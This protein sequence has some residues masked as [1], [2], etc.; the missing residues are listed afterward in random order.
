MA[1]PGQPRPAYALGCWLCLRLVGVCYLA[2]FWSF[3]VQVRGL[4]GEDGILP[5]RDV[6]GAARQ[7]ADAADL[8][9]SRLFEVPTLLWLG[10]SDAWLVGLCVAG[11]ALSVPV[12]LGVAAHLALPLLWLLYLSLSTVTREFLSFQWD[13]LLLETG[14]LS[15]ALAPWVLVHRPGVGEPP[16][17]ARWLVWWLIF[18]LMLTSGLVKLT[19]DDP[20]WRDLSALAYHYETQPLPS[21]IGW[22]AHHLPLFAHRACAAAMFA[23]ELAVPWLIF[24]GTTGRRAAAAAFIGLMLLVA[25][26]GN[27]AF[28]NLLTIA[29][30]CSLI[31]TRGPRVIA[32]RRL[33]WVPAAAIAC[34]TLPATVDVLA[35]QTGIAVPE[36]A[37]LQAWRRAI[38]P[39]RSVNAYGLFAVMSS[40]RP[41][42]AVEGSR[43][44]VTWVPYTFKYKPGDVRQRPRWVA[45]HQPRLD[46]HMWFAALDEYERSDWLDRFC[47][48]LLDGA[49][50]VTGLLA[51]NP[52]AADPPA[53]VRVRR[54]EYHV[55]PL[56]QARR[57]PV[58]WIASPPEPFSPVLS[59]I[60]R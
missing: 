60:T 40:S 24:V 46:W 33:A 8:G 14:L 50:A 53:F 37:H 49:P 11:A 20:L 27:Y 36:R 57:D 16:A 25:A 58:W 35:A 3:G 21:P 51:A 17:L 15:V 39:L 9:L 52:F 34:L 4:I 31:D 56:D 19:S 22:Y 42:L 29:L 59:R 26:T 47:R 12:I 1:S 38:Q 43:D 41:E 23:I 45:P 32:P 7:W 28:F 44:G 6:M 10:V 18:R 2:A 30:A 55:A 13:G 5:A 48:K 54:S